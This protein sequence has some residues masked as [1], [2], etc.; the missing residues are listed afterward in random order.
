VPYGTGAVLIAIAEIHRGLGASAD[1]KPEELIRRA[2][3]QADEA[4]D[5]SSVCEDCERQ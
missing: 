5:L 3:Q 1:V 4:P 2:S